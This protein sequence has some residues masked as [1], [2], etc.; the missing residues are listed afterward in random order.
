MTTVRKK[1]DT[2][3]E[4]LHYLQTNLSM[5]ATKLYSDAKYPAFSTYREYRSIIE[6]PTESDSEL[7][8]I[9]RKDIHDCPEPRRLNHSMKNDHYSGEANLH[10]KLQFYYVMGKSSKK[11]A[12]RSVER[13]PINATSISAL[14][15]VDEE[16]TA[17]PNQPSDR[18]G[19]NARGVEDAPDFVQPWNSDDFESPS[20]LYAP[21]LGEVTHVERE[22]IMVSSF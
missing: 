15:L 8:N 1:A 12:E 7:C 11:A 20:Y 18:D 13:V 14:L 3:Q 2:L 16:R 17:R 22:T 21:A 19:S 10:E 9:G 6:I 4:Q 5:K